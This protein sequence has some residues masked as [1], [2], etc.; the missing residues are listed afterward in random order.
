MTPT[1]VPDRA[2]GRP[3]DRP[4]V[5][6][7][8]ASE[9]PV[10]GLLERARAFTQPIIDSERL[11][12]GEIIWAHAQAVAQILSD[13]GGGE[14]LQAA[15]YLV[16]ACPHLNK[17]EELLNKAFGAPLARLA[18]QTNQ[19]LHLQRLSQSASASAQLTDDPRLQTETVRKML[20]AFS[21]DLRV[22]LLRLASR[23]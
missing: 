21:R 22:V 20:L 14:D 17:P 3:P 5:L 2:P 10:Q 1:E 9:Q 6:L 16:Y 4:A 8:T 7:A 12:T 18:M 11:D 19:L 23:L 13:I 15:A